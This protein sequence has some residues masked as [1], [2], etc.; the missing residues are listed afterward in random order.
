MTNIKKTLKTAGIWCLVASLICV[1]YLF[2]NI[3]LFEFSLY[4][5]ICD[6]IG[7][8][9][10]IATGIIYLC[11]SR[12][13]KEKILKQR[14]LFFTLS[15]VNIFNNLIVWVLAFWVQMS[16]NR[17][18]RTTGIKQIFNIPNNNQQSQYKKDDENVII[19]DEDDYEIKH[20]AQTLTSRLE[21]LKDLR[22]K[23][24]LDNTTIVIFSDH[25]T[26]MDHFLFL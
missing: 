2:A 10:S 6:V 5:I 25:N 19:I 22:S 20:S 23:N 11:Y 14:K 26:Y 21:E 1:A 16:L 12:K 4:N 8:I 15:I 9:L 24:L 3:Y 17:E 18:I 7:I 13:E